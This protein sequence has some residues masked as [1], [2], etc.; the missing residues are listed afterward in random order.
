[1]FFLKA[2]FLLACSSVLADR[3]A[4]SSVSLYEAKRF[5]CFILHSSGGYEENDSVNWTDEL[6]EL[7][8]ELDARDR[9]DPALLLRR[10]DGPG[11]SSDILCGK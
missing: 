2:H 5:S 11:S 4:S 7:L 9:V 8:L 1:V 3:G 10:P 6:Q